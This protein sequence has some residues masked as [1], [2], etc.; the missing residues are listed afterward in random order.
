MGWSAY[1]HCLVGVQLDDLTQEEQALRNEEQGE[2]LWYEG[3]LARRF[4]TQEPREYATSLGDPL[5]FVV[6]EEDYDFNNGPGDDAWG[7]IAG[8]DLSDLSLAQK[9][10]FVG[11]LPE[12][13]AVVSARLSALGRPTEPSEV[14]II[15]YEVMG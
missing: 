9:V 6:E 14:S 15:E 12:L 10:P 8:F 11:I 2:D 7:G 1:S 13:A 4:R 3:S 5:P